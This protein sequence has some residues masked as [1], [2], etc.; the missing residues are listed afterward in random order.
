MTK[1]IVWH[2]AIIALFLAILSAY[3]YIGYRIGVQA[4]KN[5]GW[6][7]AHE[8]MN[9]PSYNEIQHLAEVCKQ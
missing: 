6:R 5:D 4:G 1:K 8:D 3:T 9:L 7:E 2:V